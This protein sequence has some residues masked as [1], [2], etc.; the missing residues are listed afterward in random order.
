MTMETCN[1]TQ[2]QQFEFSGI[3]DYRIMPYD[4]DPEIITSNVF[5][6]NITATNSNNWKRSI[7]RF[8]IAEDWK[9]NISAGDEP[10]QIDSRAINV[11]KQRFETSKLV[12]DHNIDPVFGINI[13]GTR[14]FENCGNG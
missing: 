4:S 6:K 14:E 13:N 10:E 3:S 8:Y 2:S 1:R 9:S 5:G 11:F 7:Y 12:I